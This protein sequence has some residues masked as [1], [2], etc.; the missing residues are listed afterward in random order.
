M[1]YTCRHGLT[2]FTTSYK[3]G[4]RNAKHKPLAMD[5]NPEELSKTIYQG[6]NEHF[7]K[8]DLSLE[9]LPTN[10]GRRENLNGVSLEVET[11]EKVPLFIH[12]S[13][14]RWRAIL[15]R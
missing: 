8:V 9:R 4:K 1:A 14:G 15:L 5:H 11:R 13:V 10:H 6:L 2:H 12:R 7:T 3:N